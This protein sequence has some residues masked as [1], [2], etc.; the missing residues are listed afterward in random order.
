MIVEIE[1]KVAVEKE[2]E[3]DFHDKG[4]GAKT[5]PAQHDNKEPRQ[6]QPLQQWLF[7]G[8]ELVNKTVV[9][10]KSYQALIGMADE[11]NTKKIFEILE[12]FQILIY[13]TT[14]TISMGFRLCN[15]VI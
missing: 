1:D 9:L 7:Q 11:D 15:Q 4:W 8:P 5:F 14:P 12:R 3:A 13:L 10:T 6:R 2:R